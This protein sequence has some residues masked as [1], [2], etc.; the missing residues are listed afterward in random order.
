ME[1]SSLKYFIGGIFVGWIFDIKTII[2]IGITI[3]FLLNR[4]NIGNLTPRELFFLFF[5]RFHRAQIN[6]QRESYENENDHHVYPINTPMIEDMDEIS[7]PINI[8]N[9]GFIDFQQYIPDQYKA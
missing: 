1:D 2:M 7:P 3:V 5:N 8:I 6:I 9:S 4:P